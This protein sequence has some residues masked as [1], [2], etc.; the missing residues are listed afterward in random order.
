MVKRRSAAAFAGTQIG[1]IMKDELYYVEQTSPMSYFYFLRVAIWIGVVLS[2]FQAVTQEYVDN[3]WGVF[4]IVWQIILIGIRVF[5]GIFLIKKQWKGVIGLYCSYGSIILDQILVLV[6]YAA[7]NL[8][9]PPVGTAIGTT[10]GVLVWAI[11][12]YIYFKKRRPIFSPYW[13][14]V[15]PD[16]ETVENKQNTTERVLVTEQQIKSN[17]A[18]VETAGRDETPEPAIPVGLFRQSDIPIRFCRYCGFKLLENSAFCTR[19]GKK[20]T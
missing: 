17:F 9:D 18:S 8:P 20:V 10:I 5:T 4:A 6:I 12:T 3:A 16:P 11:P 1:G 14:V 2:I 13:G 15:E 19:C 7:Y